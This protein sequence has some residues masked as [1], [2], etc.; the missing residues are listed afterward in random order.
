VRCTHHQAVGELGDGLTVVARAGDGVVEAVLHEDAPL[1]GVQWHPEH[2]DVAV[3]Q[4][5]S[6]LERMRGQLDRVSRPDAVA[7]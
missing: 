3:D 1:T 2:P 4:L 7:S 6:L 5:T